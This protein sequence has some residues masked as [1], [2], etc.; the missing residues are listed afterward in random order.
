[1]AAEVGAFVDAVEAR[2]GTRVIYYMTDGFRL[3]YGSSLPKRHLWYRAIAFEPF[4]VGW[5]IWQY[6]DDAR[7]AGI[8]GPVDVNV[9]S[10][11]LADLAAP[12]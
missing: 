5:R 2:L 12:D 3:A 7:V 9:L 8:D 1:M 10:G 11:A 6:A 4:H